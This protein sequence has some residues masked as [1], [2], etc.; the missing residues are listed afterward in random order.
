MSDVYA[1]DT[2]VYIRA[3]RD[4]AR[5]QDLRAFGR[6]MGLRLRLN[7]VV[8]L[9]LRA[10]AHTPAQLEAVEELSRPYAERG[11]L[12]TPSSEA[13]LQAGRVLSALSVREH[14]RS[15]NAAPSLVSDALLA[16]SCREAD[17][18]LLTENVR[19]FVAIQR[20]L[21]GF[22]FRDAAAVM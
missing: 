18:V 8:I 17:V 12:V 15:A 11:L 14:R 13:Y 5:L 10:G 2:N 7:A 9:E 21:R 4:S 19:D 20:H 3:F 1:L 22:K 16:A 6:R